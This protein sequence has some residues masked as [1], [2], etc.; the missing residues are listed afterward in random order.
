MAMRKKNMPCRHPARRLRTDG[1]N[2]SK[3][4]YIAKITA[5]GKPGWLIDA[6]Y[7]FRF[8]TELYKNIWDNATV[9]QGDGPF[10]LS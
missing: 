1:A 8:Q 7:D 3:S 5:D 9:K 6:I 10:K 2:Q 4:L